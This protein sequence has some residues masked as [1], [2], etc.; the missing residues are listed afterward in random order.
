MVELTGGDPVILEDA[1]GLDFPELEAGM[2]GFCTGLVKF[3]TGEVVSGFAPDTANGI[4][5][6]RASRLKLDGERLEELNQME[7][8]LIEPTKH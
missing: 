7:L 6:M 3:D 4:Y 2:K 5:I 1:E 8:P